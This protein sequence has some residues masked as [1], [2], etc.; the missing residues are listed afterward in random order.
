MRMNIIK[1]YKT[2]LVTLLVI[3][4]SSFT[5]SG[6]KSH[7]VINKEAILTQHNFYRDQVGIPHLEW[8]DELAEYAQNWADKLAK[9]CNMY[10]SSGSYGENIYW[11]SNSASEAEVVDYWASEEKYFNHRNR[12]Y[13][14][15][16]GLKSGHYSQV[17]WKAT[18]HVGGAVADCKHGGQIWVCNYDPHGNV[19]GNKAY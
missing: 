7:T 16:S 9:K 5:M 4:I 13:K 17:I 2:I 12:T 1:N 6:S 14:K 10:H 8:S 11:T 19:I 3:L 18:T 15:G